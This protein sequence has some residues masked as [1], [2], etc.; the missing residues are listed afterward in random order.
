MRDDSSFLK[1]ITRAVILFY[2]IVMPSITIILLLGISSLIS[3]PIFAGSRFIDTSARIVLCLWFCIGYFRLPTLGKKYRVY[4]NIE[5]KKSDV[6]P[7]GRLVSSCF[8][9]L[10]GIGVILV[11]RWA[12]NV[13]LPLFKDISLFLAIA[14]GVVY[15]IPL[16]MQ[17]EVFKL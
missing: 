1:I 4:P 16:V 14:N 5:W 17:Y 7:L 13:F 8:A 10:F 12:I 6:S 3:R 9:I 11:T 2:Q 15:A